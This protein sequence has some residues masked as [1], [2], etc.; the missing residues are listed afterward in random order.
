M[1]GRKLEFYGR[2]VS[3]WQKVKRHRAGVCTDDNSVVGGKLEDATEDY[4]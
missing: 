1:K 2:H 3:R 4:G